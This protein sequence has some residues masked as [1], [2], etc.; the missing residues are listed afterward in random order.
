MKR[1]CGFGYNE[2]FGEISRWKIVLNGNSEKRR[3]KNKN[4]VEMTERRSERSKTIL[5]KEVDVMVESGAGPGRFGSE[6]GLG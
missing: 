6:I 5:E 4:E 2:D 1:R 3:Q